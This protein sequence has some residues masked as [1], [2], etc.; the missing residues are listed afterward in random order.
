MTRNRIGTNIHYPKPIHLQECFSLRGWKPGSF[1]VA[2]L[3]AQELVSLPLDPTH[4][5]TEINRVI[6]AVRSFFHTAA[7]PI[8]VPAYAA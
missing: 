6:E 8:T 4:T 1:P 7:A 2:E 3:L 5:P